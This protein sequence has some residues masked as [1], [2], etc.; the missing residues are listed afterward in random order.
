MKQRIREGLKRQ[1]YVFLPNYRPEAETGAVAEEFG[2]PLTS[3]NV[4][5]IQELKPHVA[6][7]PNTYSGIYGLQRFPLHTDLAH[8]PRPPRFL[9][10]RCLRGHPEVPTLLVD[11]RTLVDVI[12]L[13]ILT[14]AIFRPRRPRGMTLEL[15]R[16]C[17]PRENGY[18][19]RWD[20]VF[21]SQRVRSPIWLTNESG[22]CSLNSK[23]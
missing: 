20:E 18:T 8:W 23:P 10:L 7:A 2:K 11:G 21:L 16:L 6:A 1:G 15:L 22:S 4:P 13:D 12:S 9:L 3:R 19:L 17:E 14:R 5:L